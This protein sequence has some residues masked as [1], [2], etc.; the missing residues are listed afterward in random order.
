M[1]SVGEDWLLTSSRKDH[2]INV[3]RHGQKSPHMKCR[4]PEPIGPITVT[5]DGAFCFAGSMSGTMHLWNIL[6]GQLL[7]SWHGHHK[8]VRCVGLT[9]DCSYLLSG[10]DDA[11][12]SVWSVV[13]LVDNN[14]S[15]AT[16]VEEH[17]WTEHS[18]P[19][20][21]LKVGRG[22]VCGRVFTSSLDHTARIFEIFSRQLL[23]TVSFSSLLTSISMTPDESW[24]FVGTSEG[25]IGVVNIA[26]ITTAGGTETISPMNGHTAAVT[27]LIAADQG[28]ILI[29]SSEDGTVRAWDVASRVCIQATDLKAPVSAIVTV[30]PAPQLGHTQQNVDVF[31]LAPLRKFGSLPSPELSGLFSLRGAA[32]H[33]ETGK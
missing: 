21:D 1:A 5:S 30:T 33:Q 22:G 13:D 27:C 2:V 25:A 17:S 8:T 16:V 28:T 23:L 6:T 15:L 7:R 14:N 29:S 18:L 10:G 12:L 24:M 19:I 32:C 20:T 3:W 26:G 11:V 4:L 31:P 9:D